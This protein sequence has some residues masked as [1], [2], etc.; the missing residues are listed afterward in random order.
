LKKEVKYQLNRIHLLKSFERLEKKI[1]K[2]SRNIDRFY[3]YSE[4]E[5][6]LLHPPVYDTEEIELS[7]KIR[8]SKT[9][10]HSQRTGGDLLVK[11]NTKSTKKEENT[12]KIL[13]Y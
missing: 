4:S 9:L 5:L 7:N 6:T 3:T 10:V 13:E 11:Y 8:V 12:L 1:L 2:S